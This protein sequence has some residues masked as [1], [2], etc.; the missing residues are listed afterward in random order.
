VNVR[1]PA[2]AGTFYPLDAAELTA[3]VDTLLR[4][5]A[6][7]DLRP[8]ALVA[9]HAGYPYSGPVAASA[10][11]A[12]ASRADAIERVVLFGPA[13]RV[14]VDG[15]ALPSVD[16]FRT[17]L[18]DVPVDTD[19]RARLAALPGVVIDDRPHAEEHSLEVHLPF[20]QRV[21]DSFVLVPVVVGRCD[22][23]TLQRAIESLPPDESTLVIVS[24]D[25]SHYED[26]AAA[27]RHDRR[28]AGAI[29]QKE[30][31]AI[32]PHDAC[33]AY[34]LRGLLQYAAAHELTVSCL[35]LRSSGD[36]A[37]PRDHVVGYGAF[38]LTGAKP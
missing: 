14:R 25:L 33:G 2:V 21:L 11:A 32:G 38:A 1:T 37:G 7:T 13:H 3:M 31:T 5:A 9:P 35:D 4:T 20:L 6:A 23:D 27:A 22:A 36:T 10:Y 24:S 34:P 30:A 16:A 29:V 17:P 28:T 15:L 18:G 12:L 8:G 26:Y 19:A